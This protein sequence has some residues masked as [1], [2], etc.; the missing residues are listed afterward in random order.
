MV[1]RLSDSELIDRYLHAVLVHVP[2]SSRAEAAEE[3]RAGLAEQM[4]GG[5]VR[6]ALAQLGP[7]E[8]QAR[9]FR[10]APR[11]LIGPRLY[12]TYLRV[13]WP[14]AK[15]VA[16]IAGGVSL[17]AA[18]VDGESVPTVVGILQDGLS[19]AF[20]GAVY[21]AF[22]VTV[23][24]A[25][26][27]RVAPAA[28]LYEWRPDDLAPVPHGREIPLGDVIGDLVFAVAVLVVTLCF[29]PALAPSFLVEI[30]DGLDTGVVERLLPAMVVVAVSW[31][32]VAAAQLVVRAWTLPVTALSIAADLLA[33]ATAAAVLVHRPYFS[34]AFIAGLHSDADADMAG[35]L[36]V[37]I[38]I[39][40]VA[41]ILVC[42]AGIVTAARQYRGHRRE[43]GLGG[44]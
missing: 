12:D 33:I 2:R 13:L 43:R 4:P 23:V 17:L 25:I 27:E 30:A 28:V 16:I 34:A 42:A 41:V 35:A 36:D 31:L 21:T 29:F 8:D 10:G 20:A 14:A 26:I 3:L 15:V 24:F 22:W 40:A 11:Q 19:S 39:G 9:R 1:D 5:S 7:P 44:C 37:G 38:G 32:L 18:A 6:E